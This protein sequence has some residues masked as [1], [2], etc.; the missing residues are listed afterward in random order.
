MS[1]RGKLLVRE[2]ST[3]KG[4]EEKWAENGTAP[5]KSRIKRNTVCGGGDRGG[6]ET[7]MPGMAGT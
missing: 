2:R 6:V 4:K 5:S 7:E 3:Q 1:F